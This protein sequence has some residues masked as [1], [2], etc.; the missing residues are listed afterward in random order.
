MKGPG[1]GAAVLL[2]LA[3]VL[4][5]RS[6]SFAA[7][8]GSLDAA[9]LAHLACSNPRAARKLLFKRRSMDEETLAEEAC[10]GWLATVKHSPRDVLPT[11]FST[12]TSFP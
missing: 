11:L 2:V 8:F 3:I 12:T 7:V 6:P 5:L 9:K 1:K 4:V 10:D